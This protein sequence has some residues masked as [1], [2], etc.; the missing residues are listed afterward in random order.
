M[1]TIY[2]LS[3]M[4][5][6]G[7]SSHRAADDLSSRVDKVVP[8]LVE[9]YHHLHANPELSYYEKETSEFLA[10]RLRELGFE[11]TEKVGDYKVA[12]RTSYGLVG[13]MRNGEGPT[14]MVRTDLD[15]LPVKEN[16]GLS[17]ASRAHFAEDPSASPVPVMHACGHDIHMSS[18]LGTATLLSQM[19]QHWQGTLVMIGQPA[20]E[21]GAGARAMLADGLY[22]RFPK[23][24]FVLALHDNASMEAGKIGYR[25]GYALANVDSVDVTIRGSGGHGAY[26]HTTID[27]VVLSAQTIMALQT[28]VSRRVSPLES[29][30]VTVGSVHGGTKHNIIP[31]EVHLQLTVRSYTAEVRDEVLQSIR[32]IVEGTAQAAGVPPDLSPIVRIAEEEFTPA[33]YNDPELTRRL[34]PVLER[35][36]GADN[37]LETDPVMGGEDFSRFS[38][39]DEDIAGLIFWV[40]AVDPQKKR[41]YEEAGKTLPSLHSSEFAP[42]PEATIRTGVLAMTS[43][44]LELMR[45]E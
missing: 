41:A 24:D 1:K 36:L 9:V 26:P 27:P 29:A 28:I 35:A 30:V 4:F 17:Y 20:E 43:A 8:S 3:L 38:M 18:F 37:V 22:S 39:E 45:G 34:V 32:R 23:P 21:R 12:G 25:A 31:D 19:K 44:V 11:V 6:L 40:G 10:S 16:T 2:T 5:I 13:V 14:V 15:G 42:L 7:A 33:T